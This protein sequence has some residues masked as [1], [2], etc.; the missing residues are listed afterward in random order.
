MRIGELARRGGVNPGTVRYYER[1]GL[2]PA[3]RR[4][5]AGYRVYDEADVERLGF[6]RAAQRLGMRLDEIAEVLAL[7]DADQRP[8][9]YVR[10]VLHDHVADIDRRLGELQR[11]REQL[12]DLDA[13]A[14]QLTR[15]ADAA[16]ASCPLIDHVHRQGGTHT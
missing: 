14:D 1:I 4:T 6:V 3:V 11:L 9:A 2:L 8:C 16:S 13:R 12:L 10:G 15:E 7:R 5:S